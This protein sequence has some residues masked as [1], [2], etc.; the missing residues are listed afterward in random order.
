M[1]KPRTT[2]TMDIDVKAGGT[3][4]LEL[5]DNNT[6]RRLQTPANNTFTDRELRNIQSAE[7]LFLDLTKVIEEL[8]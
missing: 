5:L 4:R 2:L 1:A 3:L 6:I 8:T 7:K